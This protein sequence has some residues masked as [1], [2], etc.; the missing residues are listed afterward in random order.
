MIVAGLILAGGKSRRMGG[1]DKAFVELGGKPLIARA[2]ARL[3]PQVDRLW[4]S[5]NGDPA[6]FAAYGLPVLPDS[7]PGFAGPLAGVLAGLE[8]AATFGVSH[9]LSVAVDTPFFPSDLATR[10]ADG[11]SGEIAIAARDGRVHPVCGL[12]PV[13]CADALRQ[14]LRRGE[15]RVQDFVAARAHRLV[16]FRGETG[17]PFFNIN[18]P[19]DLVMAERRL[20]GSAS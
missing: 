8:L 2:I 15:S 9:L 20:A 3:S 13:S 17:D 10:L 11:A 14:A 1:R 4:I 7:I 6:G 16:D 12:W 18:T 5:A 19:D